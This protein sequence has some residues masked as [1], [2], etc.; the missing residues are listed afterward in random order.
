[1]DEKELWNMFVKTGDV[2]WYEMY[3]SVKEDNQDK[4]PYRR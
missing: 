3:R 1:M 2:E 4:K